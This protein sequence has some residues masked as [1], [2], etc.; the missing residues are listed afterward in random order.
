MCSSASSR[1]GRWRSG[2]GGHCARCG[3]PAG[4]RAG[5]CGGTYGAKTC[6]VTSDAGLEWSA[7]MLDCWR[8][9]QWVR[10]PLRES[11][12][13]ALGGLRGYRSAGTLHRHSR[14]HRHRHRHRQPQPV[15]LLPYYPSSRAASR[16]SG[17]PKGCGCIPPVCTMPRR[18]P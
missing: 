14:S 13:R 1:R 5:G 8:D 17:L 9:G 15:L 16:A 18:L 4:M 11:G 12:P 3:Q 7:P 6:C 10:L 2:R